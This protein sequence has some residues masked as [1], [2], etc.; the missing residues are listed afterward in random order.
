MSKMDDGK[1]T[2]V[3]SLSNLNIPY[4][5]IQQYITYLE[6]IKGY[7]H[8]T[9]V[10][11]EKDLRQFIHYIRQ[12]DGI[13]WSTITRDHIDKY[14]SEMVTKG[15]SPSTTNRSLAA[16]SGIYDYMKRQGMEVENP[17]RYESRRK[18]AD[19]TPNTIPVEDLKKAYE[20]AYGAVKIMIG[21][22]C[23]TGI[24]I[25]EMLD[26]EYQ[27]IDFDL[28]TIKIHGKGKKERVV[29]TSAEYLDT[30]KEIVRLN[31]ASGKIFSQN[32]RDA[33]YMIWQA[34]KPYTNA[35]QISPH[36]IRHT[37]ATELAKKGIPTASIAMTLGHSH[38]DTS[39]QY[40]DLG[41]MQTASTAN[42]IFS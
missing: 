10:A 26:L 11:Y 8:N 17:C 2:Q 22:L 40:I 41:Q 16:I 12:W 29:K 23:T 9:A 3:D 25:Q 20:H 14:V 33:R 42:A 32:Q 15:K 27:D 35:R 38:I 21:L 39:Q 24:R 1:K 18:I 6:Q 37:F 19:R 4:I 13:R 5:M 36:A 34:I 31:H 28:G 30:L 7:S